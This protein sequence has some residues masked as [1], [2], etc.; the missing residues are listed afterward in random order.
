MGK[1]I[2]WASVSIDGFF[3]GP[4]R[5]LDW[6]MVDEELHTYFNDRL[7]DAAA[8]LGGR[9]THELMV[10]FWPTAD[11]DPASPEPV[12]EFAAIWREIPKVV[13]SRTLEHAGWN[14]TIVR[15]VDLDEVAAMKE[16]SAGDIVVGGG[17]IGSILH[18]HDLVDEYWIYVHPV[19]V[20]EGR[21]FL[22]G[23]FRPVQLELVE[24]RPF[25]NG[26]VLHRY[27]R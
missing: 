9:L 7:R 14:T 22:E 20:G 3:E 4:G 8:L 5:E 26:V 17:Q 12:K 15:E 21:P 13:Y 23:S 19:V 25:G 1:L 6:H 10:G 11:E 16:E 18:A 27:A 2:L 24:V